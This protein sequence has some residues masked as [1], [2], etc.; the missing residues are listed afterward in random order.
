ME[1]REKP[2]FPPYLGFQF[3]E[4]NIENTIK[5]YVDSSRSHETIRKMDFCMNRLEAH[6]KTLGITT[7]LVQLSKP[8]W[9]TLIC[10]F[11]IEAKRETGQNYETSTIHSLFSL[12]TRFLKD[13]RIGNLDSD[14]EFQGA[15][16]VKRA[17]L[18]M[19]KAD[20]KG[21]RPNHATALTKDEEDM[22]FQSGQLGWDSPEALQR[23]IWWLT[24]IHF[25]HRGR[26]EARQLQWGDIKLKT[27]E[28]NG[29]YLEFQE[30]S[31]KT[32]DGEKAGGCRRFTP[33]A[34]ENKEDPRRCPVQT[35]KEFE[36][37]RPDAMKKADSPFYL[38]INHKRKEEEKWFKCAP[39]GKNTIANFLKTGCERAGIEGR[40]TN[41]SARKTCVKRALESGCPREYVAQLTGHK[42]VA[43]LQ[44]YVD[45][46]VHIQRALSA[47]VATGAQ[48]SVST[49]TTV[50]STGPQPSI[51]LNITGCQNV[52]V[53]HNH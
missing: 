50:T 40:K 20:G 42:S 48:F 35:Y 34:F 10:S 25:G 46:D 38:A 12:I 11:L 15:R 47:S 52:T 26:D 32:R 17:K 30:R 45:A 53:V 7:P 8:E 3:D 39:L 43:S 21:N 1:D 2:Y 18:K 24:T 37:R 9:N 41:H 13:N 31:T 29:Q 16:D 36:K 6:G 22:L 23:S 28:V 44:N 19:L 4:N 49:E 5:N 27:D 14:A 33:K 51:T